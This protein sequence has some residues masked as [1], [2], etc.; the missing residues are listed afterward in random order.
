MY[1]PKVNNCKQYMNIFKDGIAGILES[2]RIEYGLSSQELAD[3]CGMSQTAVFRT[4]SVKHFSKTNWR[5]ILVMADQFSLEDANVFKEKFLGDLPPEVISWKKVLATKPIIKVRKRSTNSS[6]DQM[7]LHEAAYHLNL[8]PKKLLILVKEGKVPY[9][10]VSKGYRPA[11]R[12]DKE[13]L[14]KWLEKQNRKEPVP[15]FTPKDNVIDMPCRKNAKEVSA[16]LKGLSKDTGKFI[17]EN[18]GI[19]DCSKPL[20][21]IKNIN[22]VIKAIDENKY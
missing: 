20:E 17:I 22:I 19:V 12:F 13:D 10:D 8:Q 4:T 7:K 9:Y 2:Q 11:Y 16:M 5:H 6:K 1:I 14:D 18:Y 21:L 3:L 15:D